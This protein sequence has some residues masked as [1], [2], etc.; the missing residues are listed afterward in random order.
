M[1]VILRSTCIAF[2]LILAVS[3]FATSAETDST[4][5]SRCKRCEPVLRDENPLSQHSPNE[6]LKNLLA[7]TKPETLSIAD[8]E[9][10]LI[11]ANDLAG[12]AK[13]V[14]TVPLLDNLLRFEEQLIV[15][16][17]QILST[18]QMSLLLAALYNIDDTVYS[19][20]LDHPESRDLQLLALKYLLLH[21]GRLEQ[22][23]LARFAMFNNLTANTDPTDWTALQRAEVRYAD[24]SAL[25]NPGP[26]KVPQLTEAAQEFSQREVALLRASN[27]PFAFMQLADGFR[28]LQAFEKFGT[29][30]LNS[31]WLTGEGGVWL[32]YVQFNRIRFKNGESHPVFSYLAVVFRGEGEGVVNLVDLGP[33]K[34][35]DR[36]ANAFVKSLSQRPGS[37]NRYLTL[38]HELYSHLIRPVE[39][40]FQYS[41]RLFLDQKVIVSA[42]GPLLTIPFDALYTG[43]EFLIDKY[44]ILYTDSPL[45]LV[46]PSTSR[47]RPLHRLV[48]FADPDPSTKM[49]SS[50]SLSVASLNLPR[51]RGAAQEGAILHELWPDEK[52]PPIIGAE[53][54]KLRFIEESQNS[55][56]LH[57]A[58]HGF[59][60]PD[61][62]GRLD[63]LNISDPTTLASYDIPM[64]RS[65]LVLSPAPDGTDSG[66]LSALEVASL[67]LKGT[68]LVV[69]AACDSGQGLVIRGQGI[70]GL[71]RAFRIA[72]AG[73]I[74]SALW[75]VEDAVTSDFMKDFYR[76]L[77]QDESTD[78]ALRGAMELERL[79]HPEPYF[80]APFV[81]Y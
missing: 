46:T 69:L 58:T 67:N 22:E 23:E 18:Q 7:T 13:V 6:T 2:A 80:W 40:F 78:D 1:D 42:D 12:R 33:A 25:G 36:E 75:P 30:E 79:K 59:F 44:T 14:T 29:K 20:A 26:F 74:V 31:A 72:G 39:P 76:N 3:R 8:L 61:P 77:L 24:V 48:I 41:E 64:A 66:L 68:G 16:Y 63:L 5:R 15:Y 38:G 35:I 37:D 70:Y 32:D 62:V 53:A 27:I 4:S 71:R 45:D 65:A 11:A 56:V 57:I 52:E 21:K 34:E 10:I 17:R 51:L 28:E 55:D 73:A 81:V 60:A 49:S 50:L 19:L 43:T 9:A 54:T 47:M